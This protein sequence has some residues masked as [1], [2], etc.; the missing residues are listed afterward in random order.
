M[1]KREV[2]KTDLRKLPK[3]KRP[4]PSSGQSAPERE[5]PWNELNEDEGVLVQMLAAEDRRAPRSVEWLAEAFDDS[6]K[7]EYNHAKLRARNAVRRLV[8]G[9]WVE[10]VERGTY[11]L[12]E[13]GKR[14]YQRALEAKKAKKKTKKAA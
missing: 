8:Q 13:S 1:T 3:D 10:R 2:K 14:R 9:G 4:K 7:H 12:T 11:Q 6:G 5:I